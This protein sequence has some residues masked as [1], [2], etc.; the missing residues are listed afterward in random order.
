M[1]VWNSHILN[2]RDSSPYILYFA[3]DGGQIV[4]KEYLR[5]SDVR[6]STD[7]SCNTQMDLIVESGSCICRIYF[8]DLQR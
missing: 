4:D 3:P 2:D 5:F 8:E 1:Q 6:V 7:L